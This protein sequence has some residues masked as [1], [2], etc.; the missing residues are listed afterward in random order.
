MTVHCGV[1][2]V[3]IGSAPDNYGSFPATEDFK[4][5]DCRGINGVADD[6]A[7]R[8]NATCETCYGVLAKAVTQA[9]NKIVTKNQTRV[10][11]LRFDQL[12]QTEREARQKEEKL[13]FERE[14]AARRRS[15]L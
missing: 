15:R 1:C 9:A 2:G 11:N 14:W 5:W 10:G 8:I 4:G 12:R 6:R 7:P 3:Q 13:A